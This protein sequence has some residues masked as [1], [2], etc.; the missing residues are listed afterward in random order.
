MSS[1]SEDMMTHRHGEEAHVGL[2]A[3]DKMSKDKRLAATPLTSKHSLTNPVESITL[4]V[5]RMVIRNE[6]TLHTFSLNRSI[7]KSRC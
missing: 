7:Y 3:S 1:E 2:W 6:V 4:K 5:H